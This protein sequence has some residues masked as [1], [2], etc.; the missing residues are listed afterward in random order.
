MLKYLN[1]K[2]KAFV[3]F[4]FSLA[5]IGLFVLSSLLA[6]QICQKW[7]GL[8]V[9]LVMMI[10]AIPFH[11]KGKKKL[12]GYLVSFAIN[13]VA[14]G[15]I[16]SA[17]YLKNGIALDMLSLLTGAAF[18]A[19]I[20][21]LVYLMLQSFNKTK[22][23]TIIVAGI[24][25]A[26]L[27]IGATVL[28]IMQGNVVFSFGFFCSLICFFFLCVFG[29]TINHD[30]RSVFRDI[31]FGSFGSLIIISVVVI[32]IISEGEVLDGLDFGGGESG[33]KG[34]KN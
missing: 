32:F 23:V 31:S 16:V 24:I 12:W 33:K 5:F 13:A 19:A 9:G 20:L 8:A 21:F 22:K 2:A 10:A 29:I 28:W 25:N 1:T 27:T 30:E 18:S 4:V 17:Y 14:S 34:K 15:F 26:A 3:V 6:T 11:C 7:Y